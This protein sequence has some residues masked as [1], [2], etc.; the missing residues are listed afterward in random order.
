MPCTLKIFLNFHRISLDVRQKTHFLVAGVSIG[1]MRNSSDV[2]RKPGGGLI[3]HQ[4]VM[5]LQ[6]ISSIKHQSIKGALAFCEGR[7]HGRCKGQGKEGM[8]SGENLI[9]QLLAQLVILKNDHPRSF[10]IIA[11]KS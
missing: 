2:P 5:C 1:R 3:I 11:R 10:K 7:G 8:S 9:L 4:T 6:C